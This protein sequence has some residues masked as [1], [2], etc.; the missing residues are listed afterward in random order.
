MKANRGFTL[1][2]LLVV[3]AIIAILAAILFPVFAKAR[4][5]ARQ[6]S[7]LSNEKQ[8]G[9]ALMQYVQDYD[10]TY[11]QSY[12]YLNPAVGGAAGYFQWSYTTQPYIRNWQIFVCPGDK[13]RGLAPTNDFDYQAPRIS[14]ISNEVLMGRPRAHFQAVPMAAVDA[15]AGLIAVSEI[16]DYPFAI[17]GSSGISG[18][19]YKSH[20]PMN[21]TVP[22][23]NDS[24]ASPPYRQVTVA[25]AQAAFAAAQAATAPMG[26]EQPHIRYI[27]PDRHNGGANYQFADGHAKWLRFETALAAQNWGARYYSMGG[28][29]I[30]P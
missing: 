28:L 6:G 29:P 21:H 10:E 17:G 5:K 15:P 3:I 24:A 23:N 12:Y 13:N 27:S 18:Y 30:A 2:E 1:I 7:C 4:E 22:W 19:A 26:E 11:P 25:E 20:R 14:Y 16:T 8:I 9:V